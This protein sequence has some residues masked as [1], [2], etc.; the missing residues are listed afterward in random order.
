MAD[1]FIEF[2][3]LGKGAPVDNVAEAVVS[4]LVGPTSELTPVPT[5]LASKPSVP[6]GYGSAVVAIMTNTG[7]VAR[8]VSWGDSPDAT[9]DTQFV[10]VG[11][12]LFRAVAIPS[13]S[14]VD[15]VDA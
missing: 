9:S 11:A 2:V 8:K 5:T 7:S 3:H 4:E 15:V 1:F 14:I 12:G 10:V 6:T 13:G